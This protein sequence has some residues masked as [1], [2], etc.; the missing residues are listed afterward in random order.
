MM[1][2]NHHTEKNPNNTGGAF[3]KMKKKIIG[4]IVATNEINTIINNNLET[5]NSFSREF[6][7]FYLFNFLNLK[8]FKKK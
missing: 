3:K 8:I 4:L 7:R 1:I 2:V 6:D 5:I